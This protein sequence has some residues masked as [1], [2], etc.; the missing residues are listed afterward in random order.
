MVI[1]Q[2]LTL[3]LMSKEGFLPIEAKKTEN[4][5]LILRLQNVSNHL[6]PYTCYK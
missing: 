5:D 4:F 3:R 1:G 6:F 2:I